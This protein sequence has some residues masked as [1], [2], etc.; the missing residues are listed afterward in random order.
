MASAES[1]R[2]YV[3]GSWLL[4]ASV[5]RFGFLPWFVLCVKPLM[6]S[7][8][9]AVLGNVLFAFSNGLLNTLAMCMAPLSPHIHPND[10]G[11]VGEMM[12]FALTS[13]LFAG[14]SSAFAVKY[15]LQVY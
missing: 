8:Q 13:G 5:A 1:L 11:R 12:V 10:R 15:F 7:W 6:L 4:A 9:M 3:N 14:S 2:D